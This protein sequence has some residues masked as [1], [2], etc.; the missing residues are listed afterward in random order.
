MPRRPKK[1]GRPATG[2]DPIVSIRL[3]VRLLRDID[4]WAAVYRDDTYL[5][6]R[7]AAI[8]SLILLGLQGHSFR[9]VD[10]KTRTT[11]EGP[12]R[13]VLRFYGR[14]DVRRWLDE[15]TGKPAKRQPPK[16]MPPRGRQLTK[17][18]IKAAA[19]RAEARSKNR[20]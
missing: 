15:G 5:M 7:S 20:S 17:D 8:R 2:H 16:S 12:T 11:F 6:D 18:E 4:A 10:P 1:R 13:P 19:D 14:R 9:A 3:P